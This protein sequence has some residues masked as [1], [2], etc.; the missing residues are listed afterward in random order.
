MTDWRE[1]AACREMGNDWFYPPP[2]EGQCDAAVQVC[3]GC[4]V[5]LPCLVYALENREDYGVWGGF[6]AH[7]L[8]KLRAQVLRGVNPT[9]DGVE[10]P[11]LNIRKP[12]IVN[13]K[14]QPAR[15]G[16]EAGYYRHRRSGEDPCD[17]CQAAKS[18]AE[19][20]R[21]QDRKQL[22]VCG[23]EAGYRRHY[24]EDTERCAACIEAHRE[25]NRKQRDG[26]ELGEAS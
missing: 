1:D 7:K 24:R 23:S 25:R 19:H 20:R 26:Y 4:P 13:P 10:L 3:R 15:C 17:R 16:S 11:P 5:R 9:I 12:G 2:G 8:K 6:P 14:Q 18:Q 22:A 21:R